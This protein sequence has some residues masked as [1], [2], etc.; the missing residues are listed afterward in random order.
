[1]ERSGVYFRG[2]FNRTF[3]CIGFEDWEKGKIKN[4][5]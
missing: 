2:I 1:M 4:T 3:F 5:S